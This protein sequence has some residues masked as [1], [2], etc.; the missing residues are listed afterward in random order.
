MNYD[1][2]VV[3]TPMTLMRLRRPRHLVGVLL[4]CSAV[5]AGAVLLS[6]SEHGAASNSVVAPA[7]SR[8]R[9]PSLT[10]ALLAGGLRTVRFGGK[11]VVIDLWASWCAP[12]RRESPLIVHLAADHRIRVIGIDVSDDRTDGRR[13]ATRAGLPPLQLFDGDA[14][15]ASRL[16]A[17][18][19]PTAVIVDGNGRVAARLVGEQTAARLRAVIRKIEKEGVGPL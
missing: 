17:P 4:G 18:G 13:F 10:G 15:L 1:D 3:C 7:G 5:T 14:Q 19:L 6:S 9:A 11:P 8:R 2:H 12:C 16:G